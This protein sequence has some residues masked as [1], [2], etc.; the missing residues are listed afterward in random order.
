MVV[1]VV[2]FG[3]S[4]NLVMLL[5]VF[6]LSCICLVIH[7]LVFVTNEIGS[8]LA[9]VMWVLGLMLACICLVIHVLVLVTNEPCV[10]L[11]ILFSLEDFRK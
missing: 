8:R 9:S 7:V 6:G 3:L 4:S 5:F 1:P 2:G 11:V 10:C